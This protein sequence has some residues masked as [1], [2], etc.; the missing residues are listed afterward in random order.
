MSDQ[1][2]AP[3]R[4]LIEQAIVDQWGERCDEFDP[5]CFT[6]RAW[7]ALDFLAAEQVREAYERGLADASQAMFSA[8]NAAVEVFDAEDETAAV[9]YQ[10]QEGLRL[11]RALKSNDTNGGHQ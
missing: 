9:D 7:K 2:K 5:D 11:I 3:E 10:L 1:T 6:C 8:A 4:C